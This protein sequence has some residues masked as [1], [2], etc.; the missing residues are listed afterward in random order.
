MCINTVKEQ[1]MLPIYDTEYMLE[2]DSLQFTI[3][4]QL[5]LEVLLMEIRGKTISYSSYVKKQ[6]V[7]REETL[8][9]EIKKLEEEPN[10]DAKNLMR[11]RNELGN[12]RKEKLEGIMIRSKV[13]WAEEGEN[14]T[15]YFCS[16]ASINYINKTMPK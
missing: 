6:K 13:K 16:L 7:L 14:P 10:I 3:S 4:D 1:N 2:N 9:N 12:I 15:R 8:Y 5:F 11:Q